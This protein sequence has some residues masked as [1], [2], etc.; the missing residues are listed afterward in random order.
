MNQLLFNQFIQ[1]IQKQ[2]WNDL[3]HISYNGVSFI[4]ELMQVHKTREIILPFV[5]TCGIDVR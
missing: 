5:F 3:E 4:R 1:T 2:L